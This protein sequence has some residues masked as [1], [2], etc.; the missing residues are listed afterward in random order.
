MAVVYNPTKVDVGRLRL[1]LGEAEST[2]GFEAASWFETASSDEGRQAV[3]DAEATRPSFV[4]VVGG[5]GT[6][7]TVAEQLAGSGISLAVAAAGTGNLLVR[8]L[9]LPV[10]DLPAAVKSAFGGGVHEIDVGHAT[11]QHANGT[12]T[13]HAFLV[14]AGIG[15]DARMAAG[16][17]P[18]LKKHLGWLAY[19]DPI[20]RS[21][22][23][24]ADLAIHYRLDG[25]RRHST[26]AHTVIV[27][28]CG[29]LTGGILLIPSC[30]SRMPART[31]ASWIPSSFGPAEKA[32]GCRSASVSRCPASCTA[33]RRADCFAN[34]SGSRSHCVTAARAGSMSRSTP[35]KRSS[36]MVTASTR[37]PPRASPSGPEPCS[38]SAESRPHCGSR[39]LLLFHV[40]PHSRPA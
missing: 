32:R 38:S 23:A 29:T 8:A 33:P 18:R 16:T 40:S 9:G 25:G 4:L 12:V 11:L 34:L 26:R 35:P 24:N 1:L 17:N 21:V 36:S 5:D 3:A 20:G 15:L 22:I 13:S 6:V 28:N 30:S 39:V 19:A 31:T 37:S 14:M 10:D 2:A 7:R 27:G